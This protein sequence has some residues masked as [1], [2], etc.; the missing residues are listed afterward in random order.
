MRDIQYV[1][2]KN[3]PI[4]Y[5]IAKGSLHALILLT[6]SQIVVYSPLLKVLNITPNTSRYYAVIVGLSL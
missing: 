6:L 2:P 5:T 1:G 3:G 4:H